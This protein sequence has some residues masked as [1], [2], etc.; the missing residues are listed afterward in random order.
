MHRICTDE[1]F[2][3]AFRGLNWDKILSLPS[4]INRLLLLNMLAL[5]YR[6]TMLGILFINNL[7]QG[8]IDSGTLV[9]ELHFSILVNRSTRYCLPHILPNCRSNTI[10]S[11][12]FCS[13]YN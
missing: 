8:D 13:D 11:V 4:Y 9:R 2:I 12:F 1:I 6:R 3:F 10:R 5:T 7:M